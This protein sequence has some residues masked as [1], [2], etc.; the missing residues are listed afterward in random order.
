MAAELKVSVSDELQEQIETLLAESV[1]TILE[2]FQKRE[3][4]YVGREWLN[5]KEA[6]AWAGCSYGTLRRWESHGLK[7]SVV[8]GKRMISKTEI[9]RFLKEHEQ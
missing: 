5:M 9:T 4:P 6:A 8:S 2:E 3:E 1:Q 7:V